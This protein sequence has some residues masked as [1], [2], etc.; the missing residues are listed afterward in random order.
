MRTITVGRSR[1]CDIIIA[2]SGVSRLHAE[3]SLVGGQYVYRDVS[4]NGSAIGGRII[5]N[6]KIVVA[7]GTPIMLAN[8]VPLPWNQVQQLLPL[9]GGDQGRTEITPGG[10]T[11]PY[12][13][14]GGYSSVPPIPPGGNGM[15]PYRYYK[16]DELGVGWGILS[17]IVPLIGWILYFVWKDETPHRASQAAIWAW[18]GFGVNLISFFAALAA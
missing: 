1:D 10:A 15:P 16:P 13:P 11:Q 3:I 8:R 9:H 7:P 6:D 4:S 17:F 14:A 18:V 5:L 12:H 2:D